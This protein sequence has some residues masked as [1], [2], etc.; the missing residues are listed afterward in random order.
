M[1]AGR[2]RCDH[3]GGHERRKDI[4]HGY[5]P[6]SCMQSA[7]F[8]DGALVVLARYYR[9]SGHMPPGLRIHSHCQDGTLEL[10]VGKRAGPVY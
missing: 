3:R 5:K 7:L 1:D 4:Q 2:P 10:Q 9:A 6:Q 8:H